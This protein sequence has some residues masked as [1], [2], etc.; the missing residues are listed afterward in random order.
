MI[1]TGLITMGLALCVAADAAAQ[2]AD[3]ARVQMTRT[4]LESVLAQL[5]SAAGS[6]A[7]SGAARARAREEANLVRI[8]L[9]EG[10]FQTGDRVV[11]DVRNEPLLTDTFTVVA[12]PSLPLPLGEN[13]ELRGVLRSE[14]DQHL[15]QHLSKYIRSPEVRAESLMRVTVAGQ[16]TNPG[17]YVVRAQALVG[18]ILMVAGGLTG[19]ADVTKVYIERQGRKIWEG[20]GL[21]QAIAQGRT[22]DQLSI[23]AGDQVM[24]PEQASQG[25]GRTLLYVIPPVVSLVLALTQLR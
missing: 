1:R 20:P 7:Y 22:L 17:F 13:V 9:E 5:E 12:G 16:V 8:R 14:L 15:T 19:D 11:L 10:D 6:S 18:D 4:E 23:R 3:P 21:E 2:A 24:V 25:F